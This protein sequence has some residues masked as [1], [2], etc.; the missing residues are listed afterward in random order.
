MPSSSKKRPVDCKTLLLGY[1]NPDRE[2]DAVAWHILH[3]V[4]QELGR[5]VTE[6]EYYPDPTGPSP[7]LT[8]M[9]QLTPE[10]SETL[11]GYDFVCFI[12][13]HT[14]AYEQEIRFE[15]VQPDFQTSPFT[16]HLT[17]ETCLVMARSLYG[18]APQGFILS[19]RGYEFGFGQNLSPRTALLAGQAQQLLIDWLYQPHAPP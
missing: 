17:P 18:H 19:V 2:D 3:A 11:A 12:D 13:A 5:S 9:L 15:P 1:G 7:H 10:M 6:L 16:H 8:F 14:G 4:A